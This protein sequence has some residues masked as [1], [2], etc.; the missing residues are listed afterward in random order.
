LAAVAILATA[1]FY[2][3]DLIGWWRG[4]AKYKGRYTNSWR[5]EL[6][7]YK[8]CG[9][10]QYTSWDGHSIWIFRREPSKWE[11]WL[12]R[13]LPKGF[14]AKKDSTRPLRDGD[15]EAISVL[16]ELLDA[17]E[18]NVRIQAANGLERAGEAARD[19]IPALL[20]ML[21]IQD[22]DAALAARQAL[23]A[24]DPKFEE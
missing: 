7:T 15:P 8:Y 22:W 12:E 18:Q 19:A 21:K 17:P 20:A 14:P 16:I 11:E 13:V 1:A 3:S 2:Q 4:E 6:R 23:R 10:A 9:Y 5:A 24:I